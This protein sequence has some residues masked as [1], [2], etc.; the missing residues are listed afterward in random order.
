MFIGLFCIYISFFCDIVGL[1]CEVFDFLGVHLSGM[2]ARQVA[3]Q[4]LGKRPTTSQ[5]RPTTS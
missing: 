5:K 4:M 2:N 3:F 1:F